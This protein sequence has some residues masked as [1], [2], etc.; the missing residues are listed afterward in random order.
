TL[1]R[2]LL[3]P[4]TMRLLGD[5]NWWAPRL[6]RWSRL[7]ASPMPTP[8]TPQSTLAAIFSQAVEYMP[9]RSPAEL[10]ILATQPILDMP[11]TPQYAAASKPTQPLGDGIFAAWSGQEVASTPVQ[12]PE[13]LAMPYAFALW[14]LDVL[15]SAPTQPVERFIAPRTFTLRAKVH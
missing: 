3:V 13:E 10:E 1:I 12:S 5:L 6:P 9:T 8:V 14:E 15:E 2:M 11:V 4:A 7:R